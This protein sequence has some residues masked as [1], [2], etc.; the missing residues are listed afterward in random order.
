MAQ[1]KRVFLVG[2]C[3]FL[4]SQVAWAA[5]FTASWYSTKDSFQLM[6]NGQPLKDNNLTAASWDY[7]LGTRV[8]VTNLNNDRT[9]IVT[10]T[11]RGPAKRLYNK[12]RVIDLSMGAFRAIASLRDGVIPVNIQKE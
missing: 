10:I 4:L 11:D 1:V 5:S 8:R 3:A 2:V 6:A 7:P 9:V 12:G